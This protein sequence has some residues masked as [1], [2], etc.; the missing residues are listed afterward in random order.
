[1]EDDDWD[2]ASLDLMESWTQYQPSSEEANRPYKE[3]VKVDG[4]DLTMYLLKK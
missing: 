3:V 1:M 4:P 2:Y